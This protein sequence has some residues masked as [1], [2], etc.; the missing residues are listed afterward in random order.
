MQSTENL[1]LSPEK[2]EKTRILDLLL[3]L[4]FFQFVLACN[5]SISLTQVAGFLGVVFLLIRLHLTQSWKQM[6]LMLM[7]PFLAFLLAGTLSTLLGVD[8]KSSLLF[9]KKACL[10]FIIPW[11]VNAAPYI[12]LRPFQKFFKQFLKH[13]IPI[14]PLTLV[15]YV[16][17]AAT[18][19][20]ALYGLIQVYNQWG[21]LRTRK[22]VHGTLS[23]V[24]TFSAIL[25]MVGVL[26]SARI[27]LGPKKGLWLWASF[28]II[29][30][31]LISTYTRMVWLGFFTGLTFLIFF[32]RK[33]LVII[34]PVV[35]IVALMFG[36]DTIA[37]RLMSVF[38]FEKGSVALRLQMWEASL[39]VIRDN[40][41]T[42]CGYNCLYLVHDQYPQHSI[43][44]EFFYNLHSNLFQITVDLGLLGLGTWLI[45][46]ICYF[47]ALFQYY[48]KR[49][50]TSP[51]RWVFLG[52][53]A[54]VISFLIA[55][56]FETNFY[57]TEV[58]MVLYFIMAL[59]FVESNNP[60]PAPSSPAS[61]S[62]P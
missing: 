40:P 49:S 18:A 48:Q 16:L 35:L 9:Y 38:D 5:F 27:L 22:L 23:H 34:P 47:V 60:K 55:G 4:M 30:F 7:W 26:T 58:T 17:I 15:I 54:V 33:Y 8:P 51:E 46:W 37:N 2:S 56:L 32:K 53:G 1:S 44:Q 20:S 29:T 14:S 3:T 13:Q 10:L 6:N 57:D 11:V 12:S 39:D 52:S 61:S 25:M 36:P 41:L 59:P 28:L 42:G 19:V 43:L 45:L 31:C 62:N 24:F 21:L 50:P